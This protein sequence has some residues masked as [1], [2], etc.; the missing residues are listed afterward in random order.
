MREG[1]LVSQF[2]RWENRHREVKS[3]VWGH[4]T[5]RWQSWSHPGAQAPESWPQHS[6]HV[7]GHLAKLLPVGLMEKKIEWLADL[8][9][10]DGLWVPGPLGEGMMKAGEEEEGSRGWFWP[11]FLHL[12]EGREWRGWEW[13]NPGWT[14][15]F[16]GG[17]GGRDRH[18]PKVRRGIWQMRKRD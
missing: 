13:W 8:L 15:L 14:P 17:G 12:L 2:W 6:T 1:L 16:F 11:W 7:N 10:E 18:V 5:S 3:L 4:I 9:G